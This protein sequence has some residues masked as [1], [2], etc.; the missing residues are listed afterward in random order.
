MDIL[1]PSMGFTNLYLELLFSSQTIHRLTLIDRNTKDKFKS[2]CQEPIGACIL[3][4]LQTI[5]EDN[6][7][8]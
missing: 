6:I 2:E 5:M 4:I 1:R 3:N 8:T 7:L